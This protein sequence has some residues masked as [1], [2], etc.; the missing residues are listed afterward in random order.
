MYTSFLCYNIRTYGDF[1]IIIS[2]RI[3]IQLQRQK[4]ITLQ[5]FECT[6]LYFCQRL[7]RTFVGYS[8]IL[9]SYV[10]IQAR[11]NIFFLV[12]NTWMSRRLPNEWHYFWRV[13]LDNKAM[14][15]HTHPHSFSLCNT[16]HYKEKR[17]CLK[18]ILTITK[19]E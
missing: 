18:V 5:Y 11:S 7:V 12:N 6:S 16:L 10:L 17:R 9:E 13:A 8:I 14:F 19:A 15:I 4:P 3:R 1:Y 2:I